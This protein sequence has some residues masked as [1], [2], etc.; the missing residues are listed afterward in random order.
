[1]AGDALVDLV[2][3]GG[4][5]NRWHVLWVCVVFRNISCRVVESS[6]HD[7]LLFCGGNDTRTV[8]IITHV[9]VQM[10]HTVV[11]GYHTGV[12]C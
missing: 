5:R 9:R 1:M 6:T 4:S 10:Y 3:V 2:Q 11:G 12:H 8:L 7:H